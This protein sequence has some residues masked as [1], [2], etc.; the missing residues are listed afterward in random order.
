[1][2]AISDLKVARYI[3]DSGPGVALAADGEVTVLMS[4]IYARALAQALIN[5]ALWA[6]SH[7]DDWREL[8]DQPR[9]N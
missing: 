7:V 3:N 4:P 8:R 1:M 6:E 2:A 5:I 9:L